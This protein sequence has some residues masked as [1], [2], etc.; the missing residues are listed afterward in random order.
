MKLVFADA[1]TLG[2]DIDL[3][4]FKDFGDVEIN[5]FLEDWQ[6]QEHCQGADILV[7]NKKECNEKTL[8]DHPTIKLVAV[9]ATGTNI[10]DAE[11]AVKH[12]IKVANVKGYSTESVAQHT[13]SLLFYLLEKSA[14][15][16]AHVKS[17][18]YVEDRYFTH[19]GQEIHE[20][21]N[22]TWGVVGLGSIGRRVAGLAEAFGCKVVY[23]STTGIHDDDHFNRVD[24]DTLLTESDIISIHAPLNA[25]TE[26]L[27]DKEAFSK[28][29]KTALLINVGRGPIVNEQDLFDA[30]MEN[31]I[32][33]AGLDVLCEE[34]MS[35][36]NPLKNFKDSNRLIITPHIAW[37][38]V[39]TRVRL[40]DEVYKNIHAFINGEERNLVKMNVKHF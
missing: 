13:F 24:F 16:D 38:P 30:L 1:A 20:L 37:A 34:P 17:G 9:S 25:S 7:L 28:M 31:A 32:G 29:K 3:N 8:G 6:M 26:N 2:K 35:R 19:F 12:N 11:Y 27:F 15:Y 23:Y 36:D 14:Y 4:R 18:K 40:M 33:G 21:S 22:M 5:A 39:E 10:I